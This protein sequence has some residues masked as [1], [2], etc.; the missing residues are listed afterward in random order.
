MAV[1][2]VDEGFDAVLDQVFEL[3]LGSNHLGGFDRSCIQLAQ[4]PLAPGVPFGQ[5]DVPSPNRSTTAW[6]SSAL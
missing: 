6:K 1:L 4:C 5:S 2:V 3:D